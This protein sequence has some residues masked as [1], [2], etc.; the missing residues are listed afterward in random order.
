MSDMHEIRTFEHVRALASDWLRWEAY[1]P[2]I[3]NYCSGCTHLFNLL[4]G[5]IGDILWYMSAAGS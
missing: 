2:R 1:L 3:L 4:S 5:Y